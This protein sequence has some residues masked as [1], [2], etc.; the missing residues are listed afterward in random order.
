MQTYDYTANGFQGQ[1][2]AIA[3]AAI[4]A[5]DPTRSS[6]QATLAFGFGPSGNTFA[7]Y[8]FGSVD[9]SKSSNSA[10]I[11]YNNFAALTALDGNGKP[12]ST[13]NGQSMQAQAGFVVAATRDGFQQIANG[14]VAANGG[15]AVQ[16]CQCEYTRWGFWSSQTLRT[17]SSGHMVSDINHLGTWVAGQL[18]QIGDVP[19]TGTA[20]YTGHIIG[21]VYDPS[22][23][24]QHIDAGNFSN[25]VN[26]GT[27]TGNVAANFDNANY[28]G[29]TS[30]PADPRIFAGSLQS[31]NFINDH[32]TMVLTGSFFRGP[33]SPVG[34]MG[35][36]FNLVGTRYIGSG[37]FAAA[38]PH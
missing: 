30:A 17:D 21:S 36:N 4:I 2:T 32:R 16:A 13:T 26:F 9:P 6:A 18:P 11:D 5:L 27:R 20:T 24:G 12:V 33:T 37:I 22:R 28:N 38:I 10:Y 8:Q 3:G 7:L 14:Q 31:S 19:T 34:E 35:G 1:P 23:G 25:T 15:T 29:T